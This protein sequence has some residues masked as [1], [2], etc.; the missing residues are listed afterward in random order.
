[1]EFNPEFF[2]TPFFLKLKQ[3]EFCQIKTVPELAFRLGVHISILLNHAD[4]PVYEVFKIPKKSGK[5]RLIEDPDDNLKEILRNLN[6]YLQAIY[7]LNRSEAAYGFLISPE[8]IKPRNIKTNAECHCGCIWMLNADFLNFFHQVKTQE[9]FEIFL[10]PPFNC[11]EKVATVLAKLT[12]YHGRLPMGAPTSPV[13]SN[14]ATRLLD[15]D[16]LNLA[17]KHGWTYTRFAD[18]LTFSGK[19]PITIAHFEEIKAIC[20]LY[21]FEF[22]LE[23]IKIISP[24]QQKYVTGLLVT[25]RVDIPSEYLGNLQKEIDKLRVALEINYRTGRQPSAWL[26]RFKQQIEGGI[27]FV[28]QIESAHSEDYRKILKYYEDAQR[29]DTFEQASWLEF[30][31]HNFFK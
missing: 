21:N 13:L 15:S 20:S 1:M 2:E 24:T 16:L 11:D 10:S 17:A 23:K 22:N 4:N 18:D 6:Q 27:E 19:N 25:D 26:E 29:I 31:Y 12:T 14:F 7:F 8:G 28:R 9:V 5:M 30:G 3:E